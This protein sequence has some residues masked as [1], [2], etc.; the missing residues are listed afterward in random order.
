MQG[1]AM[2]FVA[3]FLEPGSQRLPDSGNA[4]CFVSRGECRETGLI[5]HAV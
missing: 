3:G 4:R 5:Q 1:R 2:Q